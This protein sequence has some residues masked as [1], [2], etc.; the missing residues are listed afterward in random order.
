MKGTLLLSRERGIGIVGGFA[1]GGLTA[2]ASQYNTIIG[3]FCV[4]RFLRRGASIFAMRRLY[5]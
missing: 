2:A 3:L 1:A 4:S 5:A